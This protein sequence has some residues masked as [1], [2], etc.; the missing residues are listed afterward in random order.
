L[1][2][3]VLKFNPSLSSNEK[4]IYEAVKLIC[5]FYPKNNSLY[6]LA[7]RHSSAAVKV[8]GDVYNSNERLEYLGDAILGAIVAEYLFKTFP[9]KDE[10]FLSQIRSRIVSRNQLNKLSIKLGIPQLIESDLKGLPAGSM[11]GDA[12]EAFIGAIYLDHGF[13]KTKK[14]I[15]ERIMKFHIDIHDVENTDTDYK[16]K[17]INFCQRRKKQLSFNLVK[18]IGKGIK[19][20][21]IIEVEINQHKYGQS[22]NSSKRR[23][24]QHA[25]EITIQQLE[26]KGI[27]VD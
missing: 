4:K 16:S 14:F 7:F 19:K 22:R 2:R 9:F 20:E 26:E 10:G 23:A 1:F 8:K 25:A 15:V 12:F 6:L 17:L 3:S 13:E 21:F 18:E 27:L 24:E 5:G 11:F